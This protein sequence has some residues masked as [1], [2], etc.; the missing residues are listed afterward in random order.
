MPSPR[1][2]DRG[3][4]PYRTVTG[5]TVYYVRCSLQGHLRQFGSF[6]TKQAARDFYHHVKDR[7]R[8]GTFFPEQYQHRRSPLLAELIA[9]YMAQNTKRSRR[10]DQRYAAWWTREAGDLRLVQLTP[11]LVEDAMHLLAAPGRAKQTVLHY[12]KFLRH[13]LNRAVR[14]GRLLATPFRQVTLP[15]PALP[16]P[17]FRRPIMKPLAILLSLL[18]PLLLVAS[19]EAQVLCS[20]LGTGLACQ[21]LSS[22]DGPTL[23]KPM[24]PD[25]GAILDPGNIEPYSVLPPPS[26]RRSPFATPTVPTLRDSDAATRITPRDP[27]V[28]RPSPLLLPKLSAGGE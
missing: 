4:L 12:L 6:P 27:V 8:L 16:P 17:R 7:A 25:H 14:D 10:E 21:D 15:K 11:R 5:K 20:P 28:P 3:L 2:P 24:G 9:D 19:G 13:V 22:S 18:F 23:I 26:E 1:R